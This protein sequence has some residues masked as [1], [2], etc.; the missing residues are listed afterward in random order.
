MWEAGVGL[1]LGATRV[2]R[3][4]TGLEVPDRAGEKSKGPQF[5]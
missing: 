2:L 5:P 4:R 3:R 1:L